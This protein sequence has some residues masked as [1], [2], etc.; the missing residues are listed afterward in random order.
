MSKL[1]IILNNGN[2]IKTVVI[3]KKDWNA[4]LKL[5]CN[6]FRIKA[7][8]L[9]VS[10]ASNG[11]LLTK[12]EFMQDDFYI[13]PTGEE[14]QELHLF[15]GTSDPHIRHN[16]EQETPASPEFQQQ[17]KTQDSIEP[18]IDQALVKETPAE[19]TALKYL[20][21]EYTAPTTTQTLQ[22][23]PE[24]AVSIRS[25]KNLKALSH[26]Q[27]INLILNA[28]PSVKK[29][30]YGIV[31]VLPYLFIGGFKVSRQR[32]YITS[33]GIGFIVNATNRKSENW[34]P[35]DFKYF[36]VD[37]EDSAMADISAHFEETCL[38]IAQAKQAGGRILVH[39]QAGM[40]RSPTLVISYLIWSYKV[41][42]SK[43]LA[44]LRKR[45]RRTIDPNY[46]F[47]KQLKKYESKLLGISSM[48]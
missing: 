11:T 3:P 15:V 6:K 5:A 36:N 42:L 18:G 39:C 22:T 23:V 30:A 37:V 13:S 28:Q 21:Q 2:T 1:R 25:T 34:F 19:P 10:K 47:M 43:C 41:P 29:L 45:S 9:R 32:D 44:L 20:K 26:N 46:G 31:E 35:M 27:S 48:F 24:E 7:T 33:L 8:Q 12:Q 17:G 38:F 16:K 4:L 14:L 40:C